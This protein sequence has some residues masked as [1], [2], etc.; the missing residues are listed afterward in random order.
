MG[1]NGLKKPLC[2]RDRT[3]N[4]E[5]NHIPATILY[6]ILAYC[7]NMSIMGRIG[8]MKTYTDITKTG[9]KLHI[10]IHLVCIPIT[11]LLLLAN[12]LYFLK[13]YD[14]SF[15]F[16]YFFFYD[17]ISIVLLVL[18]F[19]GF[20]KL[21]KFSY[22]CIVVYCGINFIDSLI[23]LIGT[24]FL[25]STIYQDMII[26][27]II[28]N[29]LKVI[30]LFI[31]YYKRRKL[32]TQEGYNNPY[33]KRSS[34]NYNQSYSEPDITELEQN[35]IKPIELYNPKT[36]KEGRNKKRLHTSL[37]ILLLV[38]V[39]VSVLANINLYI[40]NT[41]LNIKVTELTSDVNS[42]KQEK[43]DL[44]ISRNNWKRDY[45]DIKEI[46]EFYSEHACVVSE[47]GSKYHRYDCGYVKN[48]DSF[49]IYNTEKAIALGYTPC[50][51]CEPPVPISYR[52]RQLVDSDEFKDIK[53]AKPINS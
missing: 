46:E 30:V 29:T 8:I 38:A 47:T 42:L 53:P 7:K 45:F 11:L 32:F 52:K 49:Y 41:Q 18:C 48:F 40:Q 24:F 27:Y 36:K 39:A 51:V 14:R 9:M 2:V 33:K 5:D 28:S 25:N 22:Y 12:L 17:C 15:A 23:F 1:E 31:Y 43:N 4:D 19:I 10:F 44:V 16:Y 50:S 37:L 13:G 26:T 6:C 20:W 3:A 21:Q 34:I 35:E